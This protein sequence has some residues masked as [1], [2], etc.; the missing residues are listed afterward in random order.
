MVYHLEPRERRFE[1]DPI[2]PSLENKLPDMPFEQFLASLR[3][4]QREKLDQMGVSIGPTK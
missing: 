1:S 4:D 3:F 2:P